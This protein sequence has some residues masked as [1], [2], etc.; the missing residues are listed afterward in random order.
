MN[1]LFRLALLTLWAIPALA[2]Q[3]PS[4][5]PAHG[6][7]A[8][9]LNQGPLYAP[10]NFVGDPMLP[11]GIRRVILLPVYAGTVAPP[12]T[13]ATLDDVLAATLQKQ[14][15]F[16]VVH[17]S[18]EDAT[19]YYGAAEFQS[20]GVLPTNF[21]E[22][23]AAKFAADAVLFVDLTVYSPYRPLAV[24]FR[25]KLATVHDVRLVWSFDEVISAMDPGV[26]NRAQQEYRQ[27]DRGSRPLDLSSTVLQSPARFANF[28]AD[29]MF[30]T[31]PPR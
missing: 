7:R 26:A 31:L 20:T 8:P 6:A 14:M 27:N 1:Q 15:R 24:G 3:N 21:L 22:K 11:A 4:A 25:A 30:Q 28:A 12:E 5:T 16:E 17:L 19:F 2:G 13:A 10:K 9:L 23:L 29:A 18:R